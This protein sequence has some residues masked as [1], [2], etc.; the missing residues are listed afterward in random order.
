MESAGEMDGKTI[1][2]ILPYIVAVMQCLAGKTDVGRVKE[3]QGGSAT[4]GRRG[5]WIGRVVETFPVFHAGS[6]RGLIRPT[7]AGARALSTATK[8]RSQTLP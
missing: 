4:P 1:M 6:A 7:E 2:R 5:R 8:N 3:G